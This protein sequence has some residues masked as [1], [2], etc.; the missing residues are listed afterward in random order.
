[1]RVV[2]EGRVCELDRIGHD[3]ADQAADF[4]RRRV[5]DGVTDAEGFS[6]FLRI[7]YLDGVPASLLYC[8]AESSSIVMQGVVQPLTL[9]CGAPELCVK[10]G[11][12]SDICNVAGASK[13][14]GWWLT[15]LAC[16]HITAGDV[17]RW[18]YPVGALVE[19]ASFLRTLHWP[20]EVTNLGNGGIS[21][22]FI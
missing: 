7:W 16:L 2:L 22:H 6:T 1:M 8:F 9:W 4:E 20:T 21:S 19:L 15:R 3:L 18:P 13:V 17:S 12:C 5:E 14:L 10:K 11:G